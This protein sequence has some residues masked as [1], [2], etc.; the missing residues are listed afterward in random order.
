MKTTVVVI[1]WI[2]ARV[3][4]DGNIPTLPIMTSY[5]VIV[6]KD[7]EKICIASLTGEDGEGR[8]IT[9]IPISLIK[10]IFTLRRYKS[11]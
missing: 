7:K 10:K 3:S 6:H 1:K 11:H 2:D 4:V 9:A 8:V 5:G